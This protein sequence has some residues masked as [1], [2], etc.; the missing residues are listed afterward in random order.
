MVNK[1][2]T[3]KKKKA[4]V[5]PLSLSSYLSGND[6]IT[7]DDLLAEDNVNRMIA[8]LITYRADT[9]ALL[10]IHIDKRNIGRVLSTMNP[11]D[12]LLHLVKAQHLMLVDLDIVDYKK[13]D[14]D[15]GVDGIGDDEADDD[16]AMEVI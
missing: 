7:I 14:D 13:I 16:D 11:D 10:V 9:K 1:K 12:T 5:N 3:P 2:A 15:D 4:V 8:E 6:T